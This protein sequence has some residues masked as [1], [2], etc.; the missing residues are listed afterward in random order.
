M[1]SNSK[2]STQSLTEGYRG[3]G[4]QIPTYSKP[5]PMPKKVTPTSGNNNP[6][7]TNKK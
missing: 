1:S 4:V 6:N 3:N 2:K 7:S 5:A